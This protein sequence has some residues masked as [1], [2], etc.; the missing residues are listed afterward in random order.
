MTYEQLSQDLQ[1]AVCIAEDR[2]ADPF[3]REIAAL[4]VIRLQQEIA[5]LPRP[6][7]LTANMFRRRP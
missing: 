3:A 1:R 7:D 6:P 4:N 5:D 2:S